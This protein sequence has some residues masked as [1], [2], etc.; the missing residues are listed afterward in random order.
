MG[1]A[2]DIMTL[3]N[4]FTIHLLRALYFCTSFLGAKRNKMS[5]SSAPIRKQKD[6]GMVYE[7]ELTPEENQLAKLS[8]YLKLA[9][10]ELGRKTREIRK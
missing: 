2:R 1:A 4:W 10:E 6:I 7:A 3:V 9:L 8:E 5:A